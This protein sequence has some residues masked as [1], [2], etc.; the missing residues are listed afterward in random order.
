[1]SLQHVVLLSFPDKLGA[2]DETAMR[3][4]V[5]AWPK[6]IGGISALRFGTPLSPDYSQGYQY[7]L[8]MEFRDQA[9][10]E[11]YLGHKEHLVFGGWIMER[12]CM[13]LVFDYP[14]DD[15]TIIV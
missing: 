9:A 6:A 8:F 14:L 12:Q 10:Y 1:M 4:Q 3:R 13:P 5:E 2:D 11:Q 15:T 7:L